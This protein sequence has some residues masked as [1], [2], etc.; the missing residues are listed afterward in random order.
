LELITAMYT[1]ARTGQP[2]DLPLGRDHL[3]YAGWLP[4]EMA[5]CYEDCFHVK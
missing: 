1:S 4:K 3:G 2:V 5:G